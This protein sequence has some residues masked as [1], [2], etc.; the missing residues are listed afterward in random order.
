MIDVLILILSLAGLWLGAELVIKGALHIANH[1]KVSQLFVGLTILTLGTDLPEL[2]IN[3]TAA[4]D[5]LHGIETSGIILGEIIGTTFSQI[6]LIL[7]IAGLLGVLSISKRQI[8]RDGFMMVGS[9]VLLFLTGLDGE[10]SRVEG[11]IFV[12]IYAFYF[13]TIVAEEKLFEKVRRAPGLDVGWAVLSLVSGLAILAFA[14]KFTIDS[15][16]SLSLYFGVPQYLLGILVVGLGTSLPELATIVPA[17]RKN[18]GKMVVGNLIGSNI[19]DILFTLG[20]SSLISGFLVADNLLFIDIPALFF[21][22]ILVMVFFATKKHLTKKE[23]AVLVFI[24]LVYFGA[25]VIDAFIA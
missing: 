6:G 1:Y 3:I 9:V 15:A 22:S 2:F 25:R 18:A 19:F 11:G 5:R 21:L 4:I 7:G 23:A 17:L 20:I 10:I 13:V 8:L 16:V 12:L 14:S 24:Y